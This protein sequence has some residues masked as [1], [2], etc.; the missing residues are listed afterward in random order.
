MSLDVIYHLIEDEIYNKYMNNLFM[1]AEKY[2][3]IYSS[4]FTDEILSA[5]L[6]AA[7]RSELDTF[8]VVIFRVFIFL[9]R[10][11]LTLITN[12]EH[13]LNIHLQ[14]TSLSFLVL[15]LTRLRTTS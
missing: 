12:T 13:K 11:Q 2:V 9:N 4:N 5:S 6:Q 8:A 15:L 7:K 14:F 10:K 1:A 3:F